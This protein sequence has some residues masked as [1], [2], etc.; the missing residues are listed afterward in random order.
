MKKIILIG[1]ALFGVCLLKMG[2]T[3]ASGGLLT[4]Y[5]YDREGPNEPVISKTF[6]Q[7]K[8]LLD[9]KTSLSRKKE[10]KNPTVDDEFILD[11][12]YSLESWRRVCPGEDTD[13]QAVR[14]GNVLVVKGKFKGEVIDK[15]IELGGDY[16]HVYPEYSLTKFVQSD[17]Q[18]MKFWTLRRDEMTKL[19]MQAI[20]KGTKI[21]MVNGKE[22]EATMV[23]YSITGKL[24]EK[25]FNHNYYYR[26]SDG[27]FIKKE[28][29]SGRIEDLV[30]EE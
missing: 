4:Y 8:D 28:E 24:R 5:A 16:L 19:P 14:Q 18:K 13:F 21:I 27:L 25:S 20:K 15:G 29:Q 22:V 6:V 12:D 2:L 11:K 23:Y 1:A 26:K 30:K 10:S 7:F 3:S 9:G 17:M